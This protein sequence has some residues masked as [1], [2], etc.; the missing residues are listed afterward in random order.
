MASKNTYL[1]ILKELKNKIY[2]PVYLLHGEEPFF[3]DQIADYIEDHILDESERDFNQTIVYGKDIDGPTIVSY[4]RQY[5]MGANYNVLI[6]KEA[7]DVKDLGESLDKYLANPVKTTILVL[8]HKHKKIDGRTKIIKDVQKHGVVYESKKMY[9]NQIPDWIAGYVRQKGYR[10]TPKAGVLLTEFLGADL[11]KITNEIGKMI[12]NLPAGSEITDAII[13]E[14]IGVSKDF[15][16]FE[17]QKMLGYKDVYKANRIVNYFA[18]NPKEN[19]VPKI[20][21]ILYQFF[22]KVLILQQ[23]KAKT[24][25][26]AAAALGVHPFFLKDYQTAARNYKT[27][28]LQRIIG[29]LREYDM[30]SKGVNNASVPDG[31]LMKELVFKILH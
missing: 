16:V 8:V 31:E 18:A 28:K 14:N 15:N 1:D 24:G 25:K 10:I 11:Q 3:I 20:T 13:A 17:L 12:I 4:A 27:D 22:T 23:L 2:Y 21:A 26:E 7:Q 9:D 5:P 30:K 29:Y 6:V 19:P